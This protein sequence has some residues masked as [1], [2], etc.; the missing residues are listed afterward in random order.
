MTNKIDISLEIYQRNATATE[1][2]RK[3]K[4]PPNTM[5]NQGNEAAQK[6]KVISIQ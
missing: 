2:H 4:N 3:R 6:E 1:M 5:N